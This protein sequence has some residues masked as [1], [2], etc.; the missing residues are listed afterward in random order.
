VALE[1]QVGGSGVL[2]RLGCLFG[3]ALAVGPGVVRAGLF[4][5]LGLALQA[6]AGLSAEQPERLEP[7]RREA[8][9]ILEQIRKKR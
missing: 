7:I 6:W 9:Q 8:A 2:L 3:Q 4:G 1:Q 5:G